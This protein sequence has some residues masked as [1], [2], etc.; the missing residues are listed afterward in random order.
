MTASVRGNDLFFDD[1]AVFDIVEFEVLSMSEML[2]NLAVF[3]SYRNSSVFH[4]LLHN[5]VWQFHGSKFTTSAHD[6][7]AFSSDKGIGNFAP[8]M[9]SSQSVSE[10]PPFRGLPDKI[11]TF[12]IVFSCFYFYLFQ[13]LPE[14][15]VYPAERDLFRIVVKI[16]MARTW[17]NHQ[18]LVVAF[19][20]FERCFAEVSAVGIFAV[21]HKD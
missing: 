2:K 6:E 7:K 20:F 1:C 3:I 9:N 10:L 8:R 4:L 12:F 19:E 13:I 16:D 15:L 18:F 17:D 14:K 11:N 21:D 5:V